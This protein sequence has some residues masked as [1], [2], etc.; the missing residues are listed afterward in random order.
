MR[1]LSGPLHHRAKR[2]GRVGPVSVNV[3]LVRSIAFRSNSPCFPR[4]LRSFIDSSAAVQAWTRHLTNRASFFA[5]P[6]L[7]IAARFAAQSVG[8]RS[9]TFRVRNNRRIFGTVHERR[10]KSGVFRNARITWRTKVE[11]RPAPTADESLRHPRHH[12]RDSPQPGY[13]PASLGNAGLS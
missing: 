2:A 6:R 12:V 7:T 5:P 10:L 9:F 3:V 1:L 8:F 13:A 4:A 11:A